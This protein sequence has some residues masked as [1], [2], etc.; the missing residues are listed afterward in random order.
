MARFTDKVAI[1]TGGA[2]GLGEAIAKELAGDGAAVVVSDINL[3]GAEAVA[4]AI[5]QAGGAASAFKQDTA[6]PEQNKAVVDFAVETYGGLHLAENNAGIGGA[7]APAGEADIEDR[8]RDQD[9][10]RNGE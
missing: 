8:T 1:V 4:A 10:N 6:D 7:Q 5:T 2:S 9:Q 3:E